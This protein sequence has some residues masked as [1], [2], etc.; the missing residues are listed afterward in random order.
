MTPEFQND[1]P[2]WFRDA[3]QRFDE[4]N[5][6]D[7]NVEIV[8]GQPHPRELVYSQWLTD[9]VLRLCPDASLALRAAAR[10]QHLCR[11][12]VPRQSQPPTRAGYL[13]WRHDLK[14]FHA[15]K[16]QEILHEVGCPEPTAAKVRTLNLKENLLEDPE[17][18]VLENALCLVFL[19]RQFAS[20]AAK[21]S[22]DKM[23]TALRK[24]WQ[25]M[26]PTGQAM[27]RQMA[28]TPQQQSLLERALTTDEAP[29]GA[30]PG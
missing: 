15:N 26:T 17:C 13:K 8:D 22:E 29:P 5:S 18:R 9:W 19:E 23:I 11:W 14:R 16:A 7:P 2:P 6:R 25:K 27:A 10:C 30:R 1:G 21:T 20:L 3:V 28:F 12:M 24:A 4:E